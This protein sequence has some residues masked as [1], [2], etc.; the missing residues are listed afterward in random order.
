MKGKKQIKDREQ[1]ET[2]CAKVILSVEDGILRMRH[3]STKEV[4]HQTELLDG[5]WDEIID[6]IK[7]FKKK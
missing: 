5:Q 2:G 4:L 3:G 6:H 7:G 1:L